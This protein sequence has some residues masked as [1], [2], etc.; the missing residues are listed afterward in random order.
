MACAVQCCGRVSV[1]TGLGRFHVLWDDGGA[2]VRVAL[3]G[4]RFEKAG[5]GPGSPAARRLARDIRRVLDG[6][7]VRFDLDSIRLELCSPF[8]QAALRAEFRVPRG[9]V[10]TYAALA[11]RVGRPGATR[12]VGNALGCNPFP[13]VIPCHRAVRS[14]RTLGGYRGGP[15]MKRALLELEGVGFEAGGRVRPEFFC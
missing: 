1:D 3:P 4:E 12:A 6:E 7:P 8:Q 11:A 9:R 15:R 13:I 10:T 5:A 14:D 2:V